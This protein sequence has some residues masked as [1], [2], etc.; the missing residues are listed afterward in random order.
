M[1]VVAAITEYLAGLAVGAH[2]QAEDYGA[3]MGSPRLYKLVEEAKVA[4]IQAMA[5]V[6]LMMVTILLQSP[7]TLSH[8]FTLAHCPWLCAAAV[9]VCLSLRCVTSCPQDSSC[10][11][12]ACDAST[13]NT[14]LSR[15]PCVCVSGL[16]GSVGPG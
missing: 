2:R 13:C 11:V 8:T 4:R 12:R 6:R 10:R 1:T 14:S 16:A 3:F 9:S 5:K 15:C 7:D